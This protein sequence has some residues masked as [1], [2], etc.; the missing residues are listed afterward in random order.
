MK[1]VMRRALI[2]LQLSREERGLVHHYFQRRGVR[3]FETVS[4]PNR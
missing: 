1:A 3:R 4:I 2:D